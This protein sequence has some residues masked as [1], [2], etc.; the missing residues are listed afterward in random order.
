MKRSEM[1]T[2]LRRFYNQ[3]HVMVE[4]NYITS[5]DFMKNVLQLI[6][7]LGMLPPERPIPVD[8]TLPAHC[9][10]HAKKTENSWELEDEKK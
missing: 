1:I 5:D 6:E 3:K 7:E 2:I 10:M 4:F 8:R 9:Q